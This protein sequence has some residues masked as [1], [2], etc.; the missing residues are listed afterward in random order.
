LGQFISDILVNSSF[1]DIARGWSKIIFLAIEF[2]IF[3][4]YLST[5]EKPKNLNLKILLFAFGFSLALL[6]E[7]AFFPTELSRSSPWKFGIG[8]PLTLIGVS[9]LSNY[10]NKWLALYGIL[11]LGLVNLVQGFRSLSLICFFV[12]FIFAFKNKMF[13]IRFLPIFVLF[14]SSLFLY[15]YFLEEGFF[16]GNEIKKYQEQSAGNYGL[17]V[18]GRSEILISLKAVSDSP[19]LGHG[20]WAKSSYYSTLFKELKLSNGYRTPVDENSDN[21]IPTHSYIMGSWVEAGILGFIFWALILLNLFNFFSSKKYSFHSSILNIFLFTNLL[22]DIFFSTL[23]YHGRIL[24]GF[25]LALLIYILD[26][27]RLKSFKVLK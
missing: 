19:I 13:N 16:G 4:F 1:R 22:W 25:E 15:K 7:V 18:G 11:F 2:L 3:Y 8:F 6:L 20:S 5:S 26:A 10:V 23:G 17:I 24:A 14:L 12:I 21:I 9:I 27:S